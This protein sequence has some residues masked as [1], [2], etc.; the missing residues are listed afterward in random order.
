[1]IWQI[2]L[3]WLTGWVD[4]GN[5]TNPFQWRTVMELNPGAHQLQ[6]AALHPSGVFTAWVTNS[7]TNTAGQLTATIGRD[8]AG[9]VTQRTWHNPNGTTA[10]IQYLWWDA[11]NHL[12]QVSDFD[13]PQQNGFIWMADYDGLGR[14]VQT[15]DYVTINGST[16]IANSP[17]SVTNL[18]FYDPQVQFLELGVAYGDTTE[19]KLYGPDL[20]GVYGGLSGT[21]GFDGVSPLLNLFYPVISD[22]RGNILAVATNG[23]VSWNPA[24]PTGYGAVPGFRPLALGHGANIAQS[25]AWRGRWTDLSGYYNLGVRIYDPV[26]GMWLSYDPEWNELDSCY[27]TFC[28]GDPV[29]GFD[30]QGKCE[31]NSLPNLQLTVNPNANLGPYFTNPGDT[32]PLPQPY[33]DLSSQ[34]T[35]SVNYPDDVAVQQNLAAI[36]QA[37]DTGMQVA[38]VIGTVMSG[39]GLADAFVAADSLGAVGADAAANTMGATAMGSTVDG[40]LN[41]TVNPATVNPS[42]LATASAADTL[43]PPSL[44]T[45]PGQGYFWSGLGPEGARIAGG[46]ADSGGGTTLESYIQSHD[47]QMPVYDPANPASVAAWQNA[48]RVFAGGAS[49]DVRVILGESVNP[50]GIWTQIELPALQVNENV[51]S[52]IQVN[53]TTGV[54]TTIFKK[55]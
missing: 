43:G 25:S 38:S 11:K 42:A 16:A 24:R 1:M 12:T 9:N 31:N 35:V 20:N 8:A 26:A 45:A 34:Y 49:G 22:Y 3:L 46:I 50:G 51:T 48:S 30:P 6:V 18:S 7:F 39:V 52:I 21:G 4:T 23:G 15:R 47:L 17:G 10:R 41:L 53:P 40:T 27:L 44:M 37:V 55:Q 29:N 32:T 28:G 54:E 33:V 36:G 2:I 5:T 13:S 19:W 14:R